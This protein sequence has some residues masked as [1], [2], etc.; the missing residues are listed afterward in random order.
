[1]ADR[2]LEHPLTVLVVTNMYFDDAT[3]LST[4][5]IQASMS[6]NWQEVPLTGTTAFDFQKQISA[7]YPQIAKDWMIVSG[8]RG[9]PLYERPNV[10]V[11]Y[12][13]DQKF[14]LNDVIPRPG[15]EDRQY[16]FIIAP[17]LYRHSATIDFK[18]NKILNPLASSL[19]PGGRMLVIQSYG[20]DPAHDVVKQI[21]EDEASSFV[22]RED[23][24]SELRAAMGESKKNYTFTGATDKTSL[25]RFDMHTLPIDPHYHLGTSTLLTAWND[26][27]YVCQ[28]PDEKVNAVM[29]E[30]RD[31]LNVTA[32]V[33]IEY[34]GLW[35]INESFIIKR[36]LS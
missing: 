15:Y 11:L 8:D 22:R 23:I 7:L 36:R 6:L 26:V 25:F 24:I 20:Q 13:E 28:V 12:R 34:G 3:S 5:S 31:F 4:K 35:F 17:H 10:L 30:N 33:I 16:D 18:I 1:M 19:A 9:Q 27:V 21:W 32:D 29:A 2:F 14:L